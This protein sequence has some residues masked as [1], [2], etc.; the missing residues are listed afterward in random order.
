ML[1]LIFRWID[2]HT[3]TRMPYVLSIQSSFDVRPKVANI[4][5][6]H[7]CDRRILFK[8]LRMVSTGKCRNGEILSKALLLPVTHM[9]TLKLI[10]IPFSKE[11]Q[12]IVYNSSSFLY[13]V[14]RRQP[15]LCNDCSERAREDTGE[16]DRN[17]L[18]A[19]S[20]QIYLWKFIE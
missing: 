4:Q 5:A 11:P 1:P 2:T 7:T 10:V 15:A 18:L 16:R 8:P 14:C 17:H 19:A 3:L 20:R 9:R 12:E 6:S 13:V